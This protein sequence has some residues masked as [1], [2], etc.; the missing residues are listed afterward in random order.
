MDTYAE[1]VYKI[2]R[3]E[4]NGLEVIYEDYI[5]RLVGSHGLKALISNKFIE[6]FGSSNRGRV[7]KLCCEVE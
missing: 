6:H 7:Y 4:C 3:S 1:E 2:V 5:T